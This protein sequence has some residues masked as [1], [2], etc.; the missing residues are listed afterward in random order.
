M[1]F[2]LIEIYIELILIFDLFFSI[3]LMPNWTHLRTY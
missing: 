3:H 1:F 2:L